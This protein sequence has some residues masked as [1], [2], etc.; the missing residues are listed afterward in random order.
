MVLKPS[1]LG[2]KTINLSDVK[3]ID[4]PSKEELNLAVNI[5]EKDYPKVSSSDSDVKELNKLNDGRIWY[6]DNVRNYYECELSSEKENWIE[7]DFG[8]EKEFHKTVLSFIDEKSK[9]FI[10]AICKISIL[11]NG[12]WKKLSSSTQLVANTINE[13]E[14]DKVKSSKVR[15]YFESKTSQSLLKIGEIEVY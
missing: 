4:Q 9:K 15:F 10:D 3:N 7:I 2:K 11:E 5:K 12:E 6:F 1:I 13:I 8:T 14:F